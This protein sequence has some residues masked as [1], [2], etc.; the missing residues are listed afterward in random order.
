MEAPRRAR[1][2][3]EALSQGSNRGG[4][5]GELESSAGTQWDPEV[6]QVF[7]KLRSLPAKREGKDQRNRGQ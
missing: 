4:S 6:A 3:G 7:L 2:L 1:E 5:P